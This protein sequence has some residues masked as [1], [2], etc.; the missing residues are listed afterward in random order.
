MFKFRLLEIKAVLLV[1]A[2]RSPRSQEL[3][4]NVKLLEKTNTCKVGYN[5]KTKVV[6]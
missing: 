2:P 3:P 6:D 4:I 5:A 1:A